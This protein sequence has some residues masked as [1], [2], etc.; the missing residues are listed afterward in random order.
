MSFS[1]DIKIGE[2]P[3]VVQF[4]DTSVDAVAW[5]YDFGDGVITNE[6][7]PEH[8]YYSEGVFTVVQIVTYA[9]TSQSTTTKANFIFAIPGATTPEEVCLRF[10]TEENEGRGWSEF[11]GDHWVRPMNNFGSFKILDDNQ[12]DRMLCFDKN[13]MRIYEIDTCDRI[14]YDRPAPVDK[15]QVQNVEI[16]GEKWEPEIVFDIT[17]E[18]RF[19]THDR[20]YINVRPENPDRRGAHG[21]TASGLRNTQKLTLEAYVDGEQTSPAAEADNYPESGEIVFSGRKVKDNRVQMVSKFTASEIMILNHVHHFLGSNEAKETAKRTMT[22]HTLQRE[23]AT[24]L[25][26]YI[27]RGLSPLVDTV[28]RTTLGTGTRTTGPDGRQSGFV[29]SGLDLGNAAADEYTLLIWIAAGNGF[30]GVADMIP[31]GTSGEW[32]MQYKR[33]STLAAGQSLDAGTYAFARIYEKQLSTEA[34]EYIY[35]D[36]LAGGRGTC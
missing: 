27:G 10:A 25:L 12:T 9:D 22:E 17:E 14:I 7:N 8:T 32:S 20:S 36:V 2:T 29:C 35:N 21:Y 31:Y 5:E 28:S 1:A 15:E 33:G 26:A 24:D 11:N 16:A 3:L 18:A 19:I 30:T 34:I 13:D 4:T 23:V 6:Q